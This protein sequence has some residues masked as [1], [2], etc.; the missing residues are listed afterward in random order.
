MKKTLHWIYYIV[1]AAVL[2]ALDQFTKS[3]AAANL[4]SR[5]SF[6]LI[7]G[8][9]EF[10]YHENFGAAFSSMQGKGVILVCTTVVIL[11]LILF[12][13]HRIPTEKKYIPLRI[14]FAMLTAG[15]IG[16]MIDRVLNGYV[17]DFLYFSLIDFPI[18]NVAD[19]YVTISVVLFAIYAFFIYKEED[20]DFLF[21]FRKKKD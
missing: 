5:D 18:F 12:F 17:V 14:I 8:V 2:V 20:L 11:G 19:C 7:P 6:S 21:H 16:N 3:L 9:F 15:A 1:A 4:K 13:Y 10:H